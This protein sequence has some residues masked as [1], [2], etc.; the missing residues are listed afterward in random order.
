MNGTHLKII[1]NQQENF[2][3]NIGRMGSEREPIKMPVPKKGRWLEDNFTHGG[4]NGYNKDEGTKSEPSSRMPA[5]PKESL[6]SW[7]T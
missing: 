7:W 2:P 3:A 6:S 4:I 1:L 5:Q